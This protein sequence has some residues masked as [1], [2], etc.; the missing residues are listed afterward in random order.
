MLVIDDVTEAIIDRFFQEWIQFPTKIGTK[1]KNKRRFLK[2]YHLLG[3]TGC[4][5]C[6]HIALIV[7]TEE[8][9]NHLI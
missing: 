3:V 4:V 6:T 9:H 8:E 1:N 5:D 2:Q 7:P